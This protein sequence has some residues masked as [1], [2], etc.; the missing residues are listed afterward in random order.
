MKSF[1]RFLHLVLFLVV[2]AFLAIVFPLKTGAEVLLPDDQEI[3]LPS[4]FSE[5]TPAERYSGEL[6]AYLMAV[7]L[8]RAGQPESREQWRSRALE[9]PFD[10]D[11]IVKTMTEPERNRLDYM[12]LDPN[13]LD[14]SQVLFHYDEILSL[15]KGEY[16]VTSVYP[17]PQ[18][19]A[20]RLFLVKKIASGEKINLDAFIEREADLLN[21]AYQPNSEDLDAT[22]LS[23]QEMK[24]LRDVF[25]SRPSFYRYLASPFLV[26]ELEKTGILKMGSFTRGIARSANNGDLKCNFNGFGKQKDAVKIAILPSMTK[27]FVFGNNHTTLSVYGFKPTELLK[28]IFAR[29]KAQILEA[30]RKNLRK[31]V[32]KP[33]YPRLSDSEWAALWLT[34]SEEYIA[35]CAE[36]RRPLVIYPEN[37][38]KVIGEVSPQADFTVILM[39]KNVYRAIFFEPAKDG[40]PAVNRMYIDIMDMEYNQAGEEIETI[41]HFICSRL[42]PRINI[43]LARSGQQKKGPSAKAHQ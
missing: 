18:I 6:L 34:I 10:F 26:S 9:E 37:A 3:L 2:P 30:T 15:Y 19:L 33:P 4:Q 22:G 7:V 29:L 32:S 40:Y 43:L 16:G 28:G 27:E 8:G 13:I 41:S 1:P 23:A 21:E 5:L 35:F 20:I 42:K 25:L 38:S 14:L 24:F 31:I 11:R 39:G 12:V 17:A 36:D